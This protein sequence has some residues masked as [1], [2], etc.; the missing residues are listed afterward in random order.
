MKG[1]EIG[2]D[3]HLVLMKMRKK[4]RMR[5]EKRVRTERLKDSEVRLRF[6]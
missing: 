1:R 6:N 2:S 5:G 3:H 4:R